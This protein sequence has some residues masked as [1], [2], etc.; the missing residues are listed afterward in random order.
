MSMD[1][2]VTRLPGGVEGGALLREGQRFDSYEVLRLLGRGGMG[3]VYAVRH[4]VLGT[5][6]ALKLIKREI[7]AQPG[8]RRRFQDE[9]RAMAR[10]VHPGIVHVD[11]FGETEGQTWLRMEWVG[12]SG[13]SGSSLEEKLKAEGGKLNEAE[14]R[15][16]IGAILKALA[17]A[18]G[19]GLV[20][21]DLK[22]A[23]ILLHADGRVKIS[24][25]GLVRMVG[26][27]W[28]HSQ[29][30]QS[31]ARSMSMS[32]QETVGPSSGSGLAGTSSKALLGTY[33]YMS[34]EQ[35]DGGEVDHRSDLYAVGLMAFQ[36]LTGEKTPGFELPSALV[37]GLDPSWDDW[38]RQALAARP[39][40]RF[41]SAEAMLEAL[42]GGVAAES[43]KATVAAEK[44]EPSRPAVEAKAQQTTVTEQAVPPESEPSAAASSGRGGR[45]FLIVL[46]ICGFI[47]GAVWLSEQGSQPPPRLTATISPPASP[48]SAER[49][50]AVEAPRLIPRPTAAARGGPVPGQ[51]A[52][53]ELPGG[54][55]MELVWIR[56][57][58]FAMGSPNTE[59]G[60]NA[61]R[62]SPQTRVRL[63]QGFWLGKYPVTVGQ[64]R[65]VMGTDL[66][67][68]V[69][70]ALADDTLYNLGG[71]QQTLRDFWGLARDADPA[72]R[73]GNED[74]E[75]PMHYVN[76]AEAKE[77]CRRLTERERRAGRLPEGYAFTLPTE[78]QWEYAV[79][80]GTTEATY[81]GPME[82]L[83][84][85]NAPVLDAIAWYAGNSSV[86]YTGRGWNTE[87]WEE[88]QYPGGRAG[89]REVG[90]KEANAWG[91]HDMLGNV[92]EWTDCW[93][94]RYPGG[95]VED[96]RG[97][98]SGSI[99]VYRGGS[100][101]D[102]ARRCRS[103]SRGRN[104]PDARGNGLGFRL[105]LSS[106]P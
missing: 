105:A 24:D 27:Q 42:P 64:W 59:V 89:P 85:N 26:E 47:S 23:N 98:S 106:V 25:F 30:Q 1:D 38:V 41:A 36:M 55:K 63:T 67:E 92:W 66:R 2:E 31:V 62:E 80:A 7:S 95:S 99:R 104:A 8:A 44:V 40:R 58:E 18:H 37:D 9:A 13:G 75:L 90:L 65:E 84:R 45:A 5:E 35:K 49:P 68:Q 101:L 52:E 34:P 87:N 46:L 83:G 88:K 32:D 73:I 29:V 71:K 56:P 19:E 97:P 22:P 20:H 61:D 93:Y 60:R 82:I 10:L 86:G 74:A 6:H 12:R 100:W 11:D 16:I 15:G 39:E 57:G 21:R 91:L 53:V 14:V 28:L 51:N 3:E 50:A 96:Y 72:R 54:V 17:Y 79:R 78:A 94:G 69:R 81:A 4:A 102:A 77:F 103:A 70:K 33:A 76:W 43:A 48:P